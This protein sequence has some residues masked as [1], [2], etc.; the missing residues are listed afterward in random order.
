VT[1]FSETVIA[2]IGGGCGATAPR[3]DRDGDRISARRVQCSRASI[4]DRH[5]ASLA[6]DR[7]LT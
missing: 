4:D 3:I 6:A 1:G 7:A 5:M 2:V